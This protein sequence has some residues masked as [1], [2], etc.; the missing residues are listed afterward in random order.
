VVQHCSI[1]GPQATPGL[2][3]ENKTNLLL[4]LVEDM[5]RPSQKP[6]PMPRNYLACIHTRKQK[7]RD[8]RL[9]SP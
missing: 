8:S 7:N 2:Q 3:K 1:A 4:S 5:M 9:I 6:L